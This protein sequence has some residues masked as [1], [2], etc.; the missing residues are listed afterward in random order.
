MPEPKAAYNKRY[1]MKQIKQ[2]MHTTLRA[3]QYQIQMRYQTTY[4]PEFS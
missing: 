3:R 1:M 2:F 4:S